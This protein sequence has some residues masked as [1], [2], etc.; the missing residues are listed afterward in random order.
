M[1]AHPALLIVDD[2]P[3]YLKALRLTLGE[4]YEVSCAQTLDEAHERLTPAID[5]VLV[6][7]RLTSNGDGRDGLRLLDAIRQVRPIAVVVMTGY[8][9]IDVAVDAMKRGATDFVQKARLDAR[10]LKNVLRRALET[11]RLARRVAQLEEDIH[12][13]EPWELV[14]D[15]PRIHEVRRLVEMV[16][17][18]GYSTVLIRGETGSGKELVARAVHQRGWRKGD[19][20][21]AVALPALTTSL[22]DREL[23][24]NVRGAFTDAR[25]ARP[26]FIQK[27][28]GG[29][30]FLDEIGDLSAEVQPKLLRFLDTRTYTPVGSTNENRVD[31]QVVCATNRPL[32]S[33]VREGSFRE[34]LYY[35]LRTVEIVLPALRERAQDIPLIVDHF[36]FQF[37]RQARTKVAGV[38]QNAL[39]VLAR[40]PFPGNVRELSSIVERAM[41][42]ASRNDHTMID[43]DDLPVELSIAATRGSN[44]DGQSID[45]DAELARMELTLMER[46]L[47]AAEGRKSEAWRMLGLNDRFALLRRVKRIREHYPSLIEVFPLLRSRYGE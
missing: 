42:M 21:V 17:A 13:L 36:L 12:R 39:A 15:H 32:E 7:V 23:F 31:L 43:V 4:D 44:G 14:G 11:S 24:G 2:D 10:E 22:I 3:E 37:R 27:A 30:L 34:D 16:A 6:D 46:A 9:D 33:A 45:L 26:G 18:D 40:Y 25:E 5:V 1:T 20:F 41:M 19:P 35:R 28:A 38:T 29:V 8:G 47:Y